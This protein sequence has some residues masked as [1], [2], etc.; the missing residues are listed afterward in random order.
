MGWC[1]FLVV[2][3]VVLQASALSNSKLSIHTGMG[4]N[5]WTIIN[6]GKP[7][8]VKLLD[9]FGDAA[10][11]KSNVPGVVI[12]GRIYLDSQ[13]MDGDPT[14]RAN[15]W[16]NKV[17]GTVKAYPAVDYWEGYNEPDVGSLSAM[18]WYNTFEDSRTKI[19]SSNGK[20][21]CIGSFSTGV[22]DV[23]TPSIVQAFYGA[24]RTAMQY[25]GV[26]GLHEYSAPY[27]QSA[28]TG[29]TA[30]GE[31]WL[32]GR[33]RKLYKQYLLPN[34]M[35]ISC[36]ITENGIDGGTCGV[37][38]CNIPGGWKNFCSYW[39]QPSCESEY[40]TQ[41]KWYDQVMRADSYVIGS[42]IF[43]I[44]IPG[45]SDFDIT[46]MTSILTTYLQTA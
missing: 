25:G 6:G 11:I 36:V 24:V 3:F 23:T 8:V 13:P 2:A 37:T 26:L 16:W 35:N 14:T 43:C 21:A 32:T 41:L 1:V 38:G 40:L 30:T 10:S 27:M 42:T 5:S 28:Y 22:P 7:R 29:D 46:S 18:Q 4:T 45:W 9:N 17:S 12:V 19:L 33:Y 15:E 31:G 34:G 20:K 44:D 39:N